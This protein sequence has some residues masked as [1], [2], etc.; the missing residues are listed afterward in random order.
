MPVR[1][2]DKSRSQML[3]VAL[4]FLILFG[5]VFAFALSFSPGGGQS[6]NTDYNGYELLRTD[7]GTFAVLF[8]G[9]PVEFWFAPEDVSYTDAG[10]VVEKLG[11]SAFIYSTSSPNSA[12]AGLISEAEFTIGRIMQS[13]NGASLSVAFTGPNDFGKPV[14]TC[15]NAS[16]IVP[17][18][19]FNG[20]NSTSG[21]SE[22]GNCVV[23][24]FDSE[25]DFRLFRDR[26]IY[27]LLGIGQ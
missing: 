2:E 27:D 8:E 22:I 24:N 25:T 16:G 7:T 15:G 1:K 10:S 13:N 17:V 18:I 5:G 3:L 20:T 11:S 26:I 14:V 23:V 21:V 4:I 9:Q 6:G 19:F 12:Y